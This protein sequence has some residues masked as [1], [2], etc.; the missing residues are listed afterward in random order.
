MNRLVKAAAV[1]A[2]ALGFVG[3]NPATTDARAPHGVLPDLPVK[4]TPS[5]GDTDR[6]KTAYAAAAKAF[7]RRRYPRALK[8]AEEAF[9]AVPNASTALIRATVL[10][11]MADNP[12]ET[13]EA[14]L[15]ASDLAPTDA[16]RA[17][18]DAG[19]KEHGAALGYGWATV[20]SAPVRAAKRIAGQEFAGRRTIGLRPGAHRLEVVLDGYRQQAVEVVVDRAGQGVTETVELA[21]VTATGWPR[22]VNVEPVDD[23]DTLGWAL[24]GVGGGLV[25]AG[26]VM[27]V[28]AADAS[29][30]AD[31]FAKPRDDFGDA[32]RRQRYDSAVGE[33]ET[34]DTVGYV[35]YGLGAASAVT[36]VILLVSGDD[37]TS[38]SDT[39][40]V[41]VGPSARG[42]SA[43]VVG[44]F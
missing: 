5:S 20:S 42:F 11:A 34:L 36:G 15:L 32:V 13:F 8:R 18:I 17:L 3:L 1:V 38:S 28:L 23:N 24:V 33:M 43:S 35:L 4:N 39:V 40:Q 27:Q 31:S 10:E 12:R 2:L 26:V 25:A 37:V 41:R 14:F 21:K 30:V 9:D 44:R 19:L 29:D 22:P 16:E 7:E 6:A